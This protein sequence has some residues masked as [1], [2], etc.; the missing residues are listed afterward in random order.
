[1]ADK[2]PDLPEPRSITGGQSAENALVLIF[3]AISEANQML[4][5]KSSWEESPYAGVLGDAGNLPAKLT[6]WMARLYETMKKIVQHLPDADS[7]AITVGTTI[8]VTVNFAKSER[9]SGSGEKA[10]FTS[11]LT[12]AGPS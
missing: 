12:G 11:T 3:A 5:D 4:V 9:R 6:R 7:F 1:M 10:R 8:S 2:F